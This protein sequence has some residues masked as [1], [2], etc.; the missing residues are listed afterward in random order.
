MQLPV[1]LCAGDDSPEGLTVAFSGFGA[2]MQALN[3]AS[4]PRRRRMLRLR[5]GYSLAL[6]KQRLPIV[7]TEAS[8]T[9][10]ANTKEDIPEEF[11]LS[12]A[13]HVAERHPSADIPATILS[14]LHRGHEDPLFKLFRFN[15]FLDGETFDALGEALGQR[16]V[17][18]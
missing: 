13:G 6:L 16:W 10:A 1:S 15:Y 7:L 3:S 18:A 4:D 9:A 2:T 12:C 14:S 5:F 8:A 11:W 17:S